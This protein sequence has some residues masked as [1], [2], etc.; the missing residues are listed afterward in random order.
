M[1]LYELTYLITPDF[2]EIEV[3]N[4]YN[5]INSLIEKEKGV[6][7]S[8]EFKEKTFLKR[9]LA[10]P[11]KNKK[12]AI[13]KSLRFRL[14]PKNLENIKKF[15]DS[16]KQ[17]LRYLILAKAPKKIEVKLKPKIQRPSKKVKKVELKEIE[18]KLE[19]IL[20]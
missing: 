18:K 1:R 12:E 15:L 13:L 16:E 11:I 20:E 17:I 2:T 7:D 8:I 4:F 6:L 19:E 9:D 3:K 5:K 14:D 10:Y